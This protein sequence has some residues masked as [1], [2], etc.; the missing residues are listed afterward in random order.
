MTSSLLFSLHLEALINAATFRRNLQ[1]DVGLSASLLCDGQLGQKAR[2]P[3]YLCLH[4]VPQSDRLNV[5]SCWLRENTFQWQHV[6]SF[7]RLIKA[8][9]RVAHRFGTERET[10]SWP[11][12]LPHL[13]PPLWNDS[14]RDIYVRTGL[15]RCSLSDG[16]RKLRTD[17]QHP[18]NAWPTSLR[19]SIT[20]FLRKLKKLW[21]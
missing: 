17:P 1:S 15:L 3:P 8:F 14:S 2:L 19:W 9:G 16:R 20:A 12:S 10:C 5:T 18:R 4:C 11:V 13:A 21:K 7:G 6:G